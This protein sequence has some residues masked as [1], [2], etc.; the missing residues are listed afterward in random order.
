MMLWHWP[1]QGPSW[2]SGTSLF[3]AIGARRRHSVAKLALET[4]GE[5]WRAKCRTND[6]TG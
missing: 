4:L 3:L 6:S 2:R 5:Q 1:Q